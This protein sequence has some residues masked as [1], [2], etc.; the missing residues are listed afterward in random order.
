MK[1]V[2]LTANLKNSA[3]IRKTQRDYKRKNCGVNYPLESIA[4]LAIEE[5]MPLARKRLGLD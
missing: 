1:R 5:G 4:D 3:A 2:R